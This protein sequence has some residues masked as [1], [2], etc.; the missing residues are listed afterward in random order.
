MKNAPRISHIHCV[1][2]LACFVINEDNLRKIHALISSITKNNL[3]RKKFKLTRTTKPEV[4]Y[5]CCNVTHRSSD[6]VTDADSKT[7][8]DVSARPV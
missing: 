8:D 4:R 1:N 6:R 7:S 5:I 3:I 2:T